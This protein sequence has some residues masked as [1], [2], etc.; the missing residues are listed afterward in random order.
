MSNPVDPLID[1]LV[2][3][4]DIARPLRREHAMDPER[5]KPALTYAVESRWYDGRRRFAGLTLAPT[6]DDWTIGSGQEIFGT[7][8]DLLL[9]AVGRPAGS[10]GLSGPGADILEQRL[11]LD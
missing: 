1:I 2:H 11:A 10:A 6:D 7:A 9:V 3:G 8:G 4:Q 5:V